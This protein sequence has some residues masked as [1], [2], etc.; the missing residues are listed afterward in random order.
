MNTDAEDAEWHH[1][2]TAETSESVAIPQVGVSSI[3]ESFEL[4][5]PLNADHASWL[6][7]STLARRAGHHKTPVCICFLILLSLVLTFLSFL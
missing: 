2:D 6:R 1:L 5:N 7:Y 3:I 4:L